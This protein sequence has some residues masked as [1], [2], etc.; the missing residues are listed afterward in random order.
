LSS[1]ATEPTFQFKEA[2]PVLMIAGL[3]FMVDVYDVIIFTVVRITSLTAL[4]V[5]HDK[6]LSTGVML[7]NMQLCGMVL[8]GLLWGII[9][10]KKGRRA[11]LFGSIF[12]YSIANLFNAGV[13]SVEMYAFLRFIA[14]IGLAGEIGAAMTIA[15]EVTPAK[16][17]AYGTSVVAGMG[18]FGSIIASGVADFMPWRVAYLSC[19][20]IGFLLMLARLNLKETYHFSKVKEETNVVRGSLKLFFSSPSRILRAVRCI[21]AAVPIW[22]VFGVLVSFAPEV[23]GDHGAK[24]V[25][26]IAKVAFIYSIGETTGEISSGIISQLLRSRRKTMFLFVSGATI[27]TIVLFAAPASMYTWICLPLGACVGVWSVV[28]T[29]AAE[30]FGTNLRS[31]ATTLIPNMVRAAAIPITL[32]FSSLSICMG[33][34]KAACTIGMVCFALAFISIYFMEE[35]FGRDLDF[36]ET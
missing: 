19:G 25:I 8:G 18:V 3:G 21:L 24:E 2:I 36:V 26:N 6:L 13:N 1:S 35:T 22:F 30:Q 20:I 23:C 33:A 4:G 16:Y 14:G 11:A 15:A 10:D 32:V 9:G 34:S 29:S 5:T 31:T 28:V 12:L 17:R 7:L 27:C